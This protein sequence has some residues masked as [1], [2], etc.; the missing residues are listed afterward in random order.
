MVVRLEGN[1]QRHTFF[2]VR[3]IHDHKAKPGK[4]RDNQKIKI[5]ENKR[6]KMAL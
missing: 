3:T 6:I 2:T 5:K 1:G 4:F